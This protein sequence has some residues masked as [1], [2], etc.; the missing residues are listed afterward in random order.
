MMRPFLSFT[1]A[2]LLASSAAL[3]AESEALPPPDLEWSFEGPL[4]LYDRDAMRRGLK[5][6]REVC[7]SCHSIGLLRYRDLRALGY[8]ESEVKE[9]AG[10]Y[11]VPAGPDPAGNTVDASGNLLTRP[12]T[13]ADAFVAPFANANAAKAANNGKVPPDL[14][15]I[16]KSRISG[17]DYLVALLTGYGEPPAGTELAPGASYN[18]YFPGH[19][20]AMPPPLSPGQVQYEDG[21]EATVAQMSTDVSHFLMWAAEP[22]L[23]ERKNL[24]LKVMG[25]LAVLFVLMIAVKRRV[26]RDVH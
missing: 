23:E 10:Q 11:E 3:A 6:Y 9:I 5:I 1:L 16:A 15:L 25:Y 17:P 12:A 21:P 26:W 14:S 18:L 2:A 22:K 7:A 4:G 20:I 8:T 24:G 13:P 19:Q